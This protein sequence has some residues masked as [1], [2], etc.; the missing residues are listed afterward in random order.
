MQVR[1]SLFGQDTWSGQSLRQ[2][3]GGSICGKS[4]W[5][6]NR[7]QLPDQVQRQF[8]L[9]SVS[10]MSCGSLGGAVFIDCGGQGQ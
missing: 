2:S 9:Y 8:F 4:L 5:Q 7:F 3:A 10:V 6:Q 1:S